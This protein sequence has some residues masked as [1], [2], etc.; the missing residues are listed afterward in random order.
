MI[1]YT[2]GSILLEFAEILQKVFTNLYCICTLVFCH[3]APCVLCM[4]ALLCY[5][6]VDEFLMFI[7]VVSFICQ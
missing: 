7:L 2:A 1:S 4:G 6:G 3:S 5:A